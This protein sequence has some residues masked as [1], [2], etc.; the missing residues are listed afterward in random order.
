MKS[1]ISVGILFFYNFLAKM[2]ELYI[3]FLILYAVEKSTFSF[4][5]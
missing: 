5:V 4:D 3:D 2:F 1:L